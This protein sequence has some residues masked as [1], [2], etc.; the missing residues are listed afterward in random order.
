MIFRREAV[1]D[2][3]KS[4]IGALKNPVVSYIV[5]L[6]HFRLKFVTPAHV[7]PVYQ[8]RF[9]NIFDIIYFK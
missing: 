7:Q 8:H 4:K 1:D 3:I 6:H 9:L 5:I 2:A